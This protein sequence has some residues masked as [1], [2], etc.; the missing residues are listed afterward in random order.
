MIIDTIGFPT[1]PEIENITQAENKEFLRKLPRQSGKSLND[2]F[3]SRGEDAV[4]LL[5]KMLTFD[6]LKRITV[7]EAL[8]HPYLSALHYEE[9]EPTTNVVSAYDFDFELYDLEKEDYKQLIYEEVMLYLDQN[10][11][12]EYVKSRENNPNG[13]LGERFGKDK[14]MRKGV[15]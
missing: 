12:N 8:A 4:D 15:E 2:M 10:I 1:E 7:E 14:P 9:D 11:Y 6:P 5:A 3:S 13:I